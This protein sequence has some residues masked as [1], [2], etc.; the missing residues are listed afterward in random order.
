MTQ[1]VLVWICCLLALLI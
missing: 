1:D